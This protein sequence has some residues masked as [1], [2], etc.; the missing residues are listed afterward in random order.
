MGEIS[1]RES[2]EVFGWIN[3]GLEGREL[4]LFIS[5]P[6]SLVAFCASYDH[7]AYFQLLHHGGLIIHKIT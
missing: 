2:S 3:E 4:S 6:G 5:V 7:T 1:K